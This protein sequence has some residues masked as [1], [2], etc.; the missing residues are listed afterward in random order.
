MNCQRFVRG[1]I[2]II[3]G[4]LSGD[5][6]TDEDDCSVQ[7][8]KRAMLNPA[9]KNESSASCTSGSQS[10]DGQC[11]NIDY[12][13]TALNLTCTEAMN[14][15]GAKTSCR[16]RADSFLTSVD[17]YAKFFAG[18]PNP[19]LV[20]AGIWTPTLLDNL[21]AD[22]AK[23]GRLFVDYINGP[24][25]SAGLNRGRKNDAACY[26]SDTTLTSDPNGFFGQAQLRLSSFV[27]KFQPSITRENSICDA[28]NYPSALSGI[29]KA[30]INSFPAYCLQKPPITDKGT[31]E[32]VVG[33]VDASN[34]HDTPEVMMPACSAKCCNYFA[35][36]PAPNDAND[37]RLSPNPHLQ[38]ELAA[39][40][41]E[42]DCYCA[43]PS[44]LNCGAG[45]VAGLWRK[46]NAPPPAGKVVNFQCAV[47]GGGI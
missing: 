19:N 20:L 5:R 44:Q 41:G 37:K 26:N 17:Q 32:C 7:A 14:T 1:R 6:I 2:V 46:D 35:T 3:A 12:R 18:L 16:E 15:P 21:A 23:D 38:A 47:A 43:V 10:V 36:D 33:Y 39:C 28:D 8:S 27:R 42:P 24:M 29:A 30:I 31:P 9:T 22:A 45:A 4:S 40:S 11:Y 13:C 25:N 34:P